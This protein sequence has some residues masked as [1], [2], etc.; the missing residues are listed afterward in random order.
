MATPKLGFARALGSGLGRLRRRCRPEPVGPPAR[1][2]AALAWLRLG[3]LASLVG[4]TRLLDQLARRRILRHRLEVAPSQR[5]EPGCRHGSR[6]A[7]V[8]AR[9]AHIL[10]EPPAGAFGMAYR[11]VAR[12]GVPEDVARA[13]V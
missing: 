4:P 7:D 6:S 9:S 12:I 11:G 2:V 3:G 5:L 8:V 10:V 1:R 13:R